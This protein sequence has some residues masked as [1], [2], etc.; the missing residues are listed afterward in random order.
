MDSLPPPDK[1]AMLHAND[2]RTAHFHNDV[3]NTN[4]S[5]YND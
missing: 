5:H 3:R 4:S 2:V 1:E